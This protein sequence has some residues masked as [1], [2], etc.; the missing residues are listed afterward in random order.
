MGEARGNAATDQH[1]QRDK[2][3]DTGAKPVIRRACRQHLGMKGDIG[4]REDAD[5]HERHQ[6]PPVLP[7]HDLASHGD[8][9]AGQ[10]QAV[11]DDRNDRSRHTRGEK[12][13]TAK[14]P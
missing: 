4:G 7:D 12:G 13:D 11:D 1:D 8:K 3:R 5:Q 14:A 6:V 2:R 10:E 9:Q